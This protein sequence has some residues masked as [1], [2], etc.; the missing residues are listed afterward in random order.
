VAAVW[1]HQNV[2][3]TSTN[4]SDSLGSL[5]LREIGAISIPI[6]VSS[7]TRYRTPIASTPRTKRGTGAVGK[8]FLQPGIQQK[9]D[10]FCD[11]EIR[12]ATV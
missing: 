3:D 10:D 7:F 6:S 4:R 8:R 1:R 11:V 9:R 5:L 2:K 12:R